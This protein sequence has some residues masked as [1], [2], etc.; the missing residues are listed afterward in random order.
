M[1]N[2]TVW[3]GRHLVTRDQLQK[4]KNILEAEQVGAGR[5]LLEKPSVVGSRRKCNEIDLEGKERKLC[6]K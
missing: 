1:S 3:Q 4:F 2:L 5:T 6:L